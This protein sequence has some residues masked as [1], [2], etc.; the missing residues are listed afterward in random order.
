MRLA[1]QLVS[2]AFGLFF[3][4]A[5]GA[6]LDGWRQW[7]LDVAAWTPNPAYRAI[8]RTGIPC[9]EAGATVLLFTSP[10]LGLPVAAAALLGFSVG[11]LLLRRTR[12]GVKCGCFGTRSRSTIGLGLALR[13]MGLCAL[14]GAGAIAAR[15]YDA[16]PLPASGV[17][18]AV[19]AGAGILLLIEYRSL[20]Q[21]ALT[22]QEGT[23]S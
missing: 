10:M 18:L 14:A 13:N 3:L 16:G 8:A 23:P 19:V 9:L 2:C 11:V 12:E 7:S 20:N 1:P 15:R 21:I 22:A 4:A 17:L 6:K 5:L